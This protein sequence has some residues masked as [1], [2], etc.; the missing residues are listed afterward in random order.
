MKHT[1]REPADWAEA[2]AE[3]L[4]AFESWQAAARVGE[5][6]ILVLKQADLLG[7]GSVLG[8]IVANALLSALR[9]M[10]AEGH[11][12]NAIAVGDDVDESDFA[13]W[14]AVLAD[15]D[16]VNGELIHVHAAHVGKLPT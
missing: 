7:Q 12:A 8:A 4:R 16:G 10:A 9:T 13:H 14:V 15:G 6:V 5:P 2:E 3:L 1:A 11:R